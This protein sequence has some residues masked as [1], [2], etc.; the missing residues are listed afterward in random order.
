MDN[1]SDRILTA[2][3]PPVKLLQYVYRGTGVL[4]YLILVVHRYE[5][6]HT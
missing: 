1:L 3:H 5:R 2:C 6:A 4:R